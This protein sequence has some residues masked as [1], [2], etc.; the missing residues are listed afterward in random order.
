MS[1]YKKIY[2][3]DVYAQS[4]DT[5]SPAILTIGTSSATKLE[6]AGTGV[7]S[8]IKGS[9]TVATTAD[10]NGKVT[11]GETR[12]DPSSSNTFTISTNHYT[13]GT[14]S[15]IAPTGSQFI[16]VKLWGAGGGGGKGNPTEGDKSSGGGGGYTFIR[17][18]AAAG[19][20]FWLTVGVEGTNSIVG[21]NGGNNG[22]HGEGG[23][24]SGTSYYGGSGGSYSAIHKQVGTTYTLI[25]CAGGGGGGGSDNTT[26]GVGG[27]GNGG[28]G[29]DA[30]DIGGA[31]GTAGVGG[32][33]GNLG[34]DGND[35]GTLSHTDAVTATALA[36]FGGAGGA[37]T[38][39]GGGGGGGYGGGEAGYLSSG[40]G[41]GGGFAHPDGSNV[42][43]VT[44]TG[45]L[46]GNSGD[47][48]IIGDAGKGATVALDDGSGGQITIRA[49]ASEDNWNDQEI[50]VHDGN[51]LSL[52]NFT[53]SAKVVVKNQSQVH[54][55]GTRV[56]KDGVH[57]RFET[58][59]GGAHS[60]DDTNHVVA[61]SLASAVAVSLPSAP[62][63]GSS[64]G[65]TYELI[66]T[67]SSASGNVVITAD[68]TD[69][70]NVHGSL[71][72]S[73]TLTNQYDTVKLM[74]N[75][76]GTWHSFAPSSSMTSIEHVATNYTAG[77]QNLESHLSGIDAQLSSQTATDISVAHSEVNYTADGNVEAHIAAIDG[78]LG[79]LAASNISV[80][81]SEVNYTA[82]DNIE[83]HIAA[84]DGALGSHTHVATDITDFNTAADA[85]ITLQAGAANGLAT[86]DA[87][88]T[89][90]TSQ[91][92]LP[93]STTFIGTWDANTNTPTL[94]DG[95]GVSVGDYYTVSVAGST[96][97]D[98]I[99]AWGLGDQI[100]VIT[101][102][103]WDK[104]SN[105]TAVTS[106]AGKTGTV[107][108][109]LADV[110]DLANTSD[111][112]EDPSYLYYTEA[113][114]DANTNVTA[115][116][117]HRVLTN[118]PHSVTKT[119]IGLSNVE[120]TVHKVN[121]TQAPSV[122][123]D[124][125]NTSGNGVFSVGSV[126]V[127]TT[128]DKAYICVNIA[129]T[130]AVWLLTTTLTS[131]DITEGAAN[132]FYTDAQVS[133]WINTQKGVNNGIAELNAS[134]KIPSSQLDV[135][136]LTYLGAWN[137]STNTPTITSGV[138]G[139]GE[140]YTVSVAGSTVVDGVSSWQVGD[141]VI[142]GSTVWDKI[143]QTNSVTSVAGKQGLVTLVL[144]DITDLTDSGDLPEGAANKYYTEGRVSANV[145]VVANT[146][147]AG[148]T[149]N[150]HSVT[151]AQVGL[152]NVIN[153]VNK[154]DGTTNPTF[155]DDSS[156]TSG[157]GLFSVGSV[158][159]DVVG[160][161][162]YT[163][164]DAA[165]STALWT[166]TTIN[167]SGAEINT[168]SSTG[169][170]SLV[171]PKVGVDLQVKGLTATSSKIIIT[172]NA[173]DIG[174]DVNQ[175]DLV[176][177]GI[178]NFGSISSGYGSIDIG[179]SPFSSGQATIDNVFI[180]DSSITLSGTT[181]NNQ[182]VV[183]DNVADGY[184]I[185]D[186]TL[187]YLT[188]T[189]TN[190]SEEI[191]LRR[192]TSLTGN[193]TQT[194]DMGITGQLTVDQTNINGAV[195]TLSGTTGNNQ[196]VVTDNVADGY[197][198]S[199]GTLDYL[200]LTTTNA[201]EEIKLYRNTSLT[202]NFTQTGDMGITGQLTVDQTN[203]D[204]AVTTLSGTTGNNQL[205]VT[206]NVADGYT[207]SDGTLDY[208][209]LTTTNASEEI[210]LHRNTS[211][212][213]NFA[214]T[215][216]YIQ[217]D[218]IAAPVNPA[219]GQ[220]RLYKKAG[221]RGVW[222]RPNS[223]DDEVNLADSS[224]R[225]EVSTSTY[226]PSGYPATLGVTYTPT[227]TVTITLPLANSEPAGTVYHV[228]DEGGNATVN[229]IVFNTTGGELLSGQASGIMQIDNSYSCLSV[230]TNGVSA[231]FVR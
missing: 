75:G 98:G 128:N 3:N 185:S 21:G 190:A 143:D 62:L 102:G 162:S 149:N 217:V 172:A 39:G 4:M 14:V 28:N 219:D 212:T 156:N 49:T 121:G 45:Y 63:A 160:N 106:V 141:W 170:T 6:L 109:T 27:G 146:T 119:Q 152:G 2:A 114:V 7:I 92:N 182:L 163:C 193:F 159:I 78:A 166:E 216:G 46:P 229:P 226:A 33:G 186:G 38:D 111:L 12:A 86:L 94:T 151:K 42:V 139:S 204:G 136:A 184:T 11:L 101:G 74:S 113:R 23:D 178:L 20:Q 207:I 84:I 88:G 203:I 67:S 51:D 218:D 15:Y 29:G 31:G 137:A 208:L 112:P 36:L 30:L 123:D 165:T 153:T 48:D 82:A 96:T 54:V 157:N 180:N 213:G 131:D 107:V 181:G 10:I 173:N 135:S 164:V 126:W 124:G 148:L 122:N 32:A 61:Y 72:S 95:S 134:G 69:T 85:R 198:I 65:K 228:V 205:V 26:S 76:A 167:A 187:D 99:S 52:T 133:T 58:I 118:N 68:G 230:Y 81:H 199:D 155:N 73:V 192:N 44:S 117:A 222:W 34:A 188:L 132:K 110:T 129:T 55:E 138:G 147:H 40:G 224:R 215:T 89:V 93:S 125:A 209:T 177:T 195:T 183:T 179:V 202:G 189:T 79:S 191:K 5:T 1:V 161:R 105:P 19:D 227:G 66:K 57:A 87:G 97:V 71:V 194:G 70:I 59:T 154:F 196:L 104:I 17:Y 60:L 64:A 47:V 214:Q 77:S 108:L 225:I 220:G 13:T 210:K 176:G 169:G 201:S 211:L 174:I 53:G 80:T 8:E 158:W 56:Y 231:W 37:G 221:D 116:S 16:E 144:D 83:A 35:Y 50:T 175:S 197:T 43:T 91:L 206:D 103:A 18:P 22:D 25:A 115:N 150:P 142:F 171:Q 223:A 127:D 41:G 100:I 140:Y 168:I 145:S 90:P 200:T 24:A 9:V 130:A 120:N